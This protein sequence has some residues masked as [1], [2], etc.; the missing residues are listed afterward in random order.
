[1]NDGYLVSGNGVAGSN[2]LSLQDVQAR[3]GTWS[4]ARYD[5][6]GRMLMSVDSQGRLTSYG[7]CRCGS[8]KS[9]TDPLGRTTRWVRDV[10]GRVTEKIMPDGKKYSV[11]YQPASGRVDTLTMP[12]D[13]ASGHY[14]TKLSYDVD[15]SLY[16][17]DFFDP[18]TPDVTFGRDHLGR[19]SSLTDNLG[20]TAYTYFPLNTPLTGGKLWKAN[21]PWANDTFEL[22]YDDFGRPTGGTIKAD[23][24]DVLYNNQM[25]LDDLGRVTDI[26][27]DLGTST[28]NFQAGTLGRL[29]SVSGPAGFSQSMNY[30]PNDQPGKSGEISLLE[31]T[32]PGV[33]LLNYGMDYDSVGRLKTLNE[34]VAGQTTSKAFSYYPT[35]ELNTTVKTPPPGQGDTTSEFFQYDPAGNR[36]RINSKVGLAAGPGVDSLAWHGTRNQLERLGGGGLTL[37]EGTVTGGYTTATGPIKGA[38]TVTIAVGTQT[39]LTP[40]PARVREIGNAVYPTIPTYRFEKEIALTSSDNSLPQNHVITIEAKDGSTTPKKTTNRY[41]VTVSPQSDTFTYDDNGNMLTHTTG[42]GTANPVTRKYEWDAANRLKAVQI[43][44]PPVNGTLRS[45]FDYDGLDR[46]VK[47]REKHYDG[48][49]WVLDSEVTWLWCADSICQKRSADGS[50]PTRSY[51]QGGMKEGNSKYLYTRDHLGSIREVVNITGATPSVT[52][53]YDYDSWGQRTRTIT[54]GAGA[55]FGYTGH[56]QNEATGLCLAKYRAYSASLGRWLSEDPFGEA[57]GMNLFA[58]VGNDPIGMLDPL[59]LAGY[60]ASGNLVY[61]G[62]LDWAVSNDWTRPIL[63][64]DALGTGK[65]YL[66]GVADGLSFGIGPMLRDQVDFYDGSVDYC[67]TAYKAGQLSSLLSPGGGR[68]VYAGGAKLISFIARG[69]GMGAARGAFLARNGWKIFMRGGLWG[70]SGLRASAWEAFK[71]IP[72]YKGL[73]SELIAAAGRT[74]MKWHLWGAITSL[75][76]L[77]QRNFLPSSNQCD[78]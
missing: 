70:W 78:E 48:T 71:A 63:A 45:E 46:R 50:T 7:W 8:M 30:F 35:G 59:G 13:Q 5:H 21:G 60:D 14:T 67:A 54:N 6:N 34:T 39:P 29:E 47:T 40:Q 61:D 33:E 56:L 38:P 15:G 65:T 25:T 18:N 64:S 58:Y 32:L 24:G 2:T 11:T 10:V 43:T 1:M 31:Q 66:T 26:T 20:T 55:D 53:R 74:N 76:Q 52:A 49:A 69:G 17:R 73:P 23:N 16:K 9:L 57:G 4:H 51:Y 36:A 41:Q 19:A 27:N 68:A 37:V 22:T 12:N 62:F 72:K 77:L 42:V 3:D 75:G 28:Y 44:A